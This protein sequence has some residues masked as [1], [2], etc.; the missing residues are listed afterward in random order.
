MRRV[1]SKQQSV[2]NETEIDEFFGTLLL[3][4][5]K[6]LCEK[7]KNSEKKNCVIRSKLG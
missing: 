4:E 6:I 7:K 5:H 2:S 1:L 3:E